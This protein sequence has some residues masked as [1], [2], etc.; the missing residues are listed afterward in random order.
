[1]LTRLLYC[2]GQVL[3]KTLQLID[4]LLQTANVEWVAYA[5]KH[6]AGT[7]GPLEAAAKFSQLDPKHGDRP[8]QMIRQG[9]DRLLKAFQSEKDDDG[10]QFLVD[11]SVEELPTVLAELGLEPEGSSIEQRAKLCAF[12][13]P[14]DLAASH[15]E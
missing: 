4:R 9:G 5:R 15:N 2:T 14:E 8:A 6:C 11:T 7:D 1:V 12:L 13:M 3:L 10:L